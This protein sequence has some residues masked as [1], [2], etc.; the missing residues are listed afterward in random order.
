M[1]LSI[2]PFA[3]L[4]PRPAL[5][6]QP[7]D[8]FREWLAGQGQPALRLK[9]LKRWILAKRAESFETMSDLPKELR[10]ALTENYS[11]LGTRIERHL[12]ARDETHKLLV[13]LHDGRTI[14]CVLIQDA[15]ARRSVAPWAACFAPRD[16]MA[17]SAT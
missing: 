4:T 14:E 2:L 11:P 12:A 17:W 5:L 16:S 15:S 6:E 7:D 8:A 1:E 13:K 10:A 9:Q 3:P